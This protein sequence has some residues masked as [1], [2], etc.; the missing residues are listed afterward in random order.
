MDI[1]I[2]L[3]RLFCVTLNPL[4]P[5][6]SGETETQLR[7]AG[8]VESENVFGPTLVAPT[9]VRER[10][11]PA[12]AEA[13]V[14]WSI[15]SNQARTFS[16]METLALTISDNANKIASSIRAK[17]SEEEDNKAYP[18]VEEDL[19]GVSTYVTLAAGGYIRARSETSDALERAK[20][21][22]VTLM[23]EFNYERQL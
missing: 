9:A 14:E 19:N 12:L 15:T 11:I 4:E 20:H 2:D 7:E 17:L 10:L 13:I 1:A 23:T 21:K 5:E 18:I 16:L 22:L 8:W 6:I 3:R